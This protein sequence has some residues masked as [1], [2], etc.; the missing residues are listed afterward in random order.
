MS[1]SWPTWRANT[2]CRQSNSDTLPFDIEC[3][4]INVDL[5][6][7]IGSPERH[8]K[9]FASFHRTAANLDIRMSNTTRINYR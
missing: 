5:R 8:A 1:R 6:I 3:V 2:Y 4:W 9:G 7:V